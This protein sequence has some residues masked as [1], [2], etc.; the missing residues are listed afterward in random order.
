MSSSVKVERKKRSAVLH[1]ACLYKPK[2]K[3]ERIA[4]KRTRTLEDILQGPTSDERVKGDSFYTFRIEAPKVAPRPM[5]MIKAENANG[6]KIKVE[7]GGTTAMTVQGGGVMSVENGII[8]N[9]NRVDMCRS[10][11]ADAIVHNEREGSL[12]CSRCGLVQSERE[13]VST[14][15]DV[16]RV[17]KPCAIL[18]DRTHVNYSYG[19]A[20]KD[21]IAKHPLTSHLSETATEKHARLCL[22]IINDLWHVVVSKTMRGSIGFLI[23]QGAQFAQENRQMP[24][25]ARCVDIILRKILTNEVVP[26]MYTKFL[27]AGIQKYQPKD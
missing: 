14:F 9:L 26:H 23:T 5:L 10:C 1:S 15:S 7:G 13:V 2:P 18:G 25:T 11:G 12:T 24:D 3:N 20:L 6:M 8:T 21:A 16:E 19:Q 22:L 27:L 17:L 4:T